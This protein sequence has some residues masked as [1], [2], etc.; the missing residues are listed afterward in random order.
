MIV[1]QLK[2]IS[3]NIKYSLAINFPSIAKPIQYRRYNKMLFPKVDVKLIP[4]AELFFINELIEPNTTVLDIGSNEGIFL[5]LF[6]KTNRYSR[7]IGF[8]PIPALNKRLKAF[9]PKLEVFDFAISNKTQTST[10][11]VPLI[12]NKRYDTRGTLEKFE[13]INET[14]SSTFEVK[15]ITLDEFVEKNNIQN[16]GGIKIDVEG[17]ELSAI[18]GAK[19]TLQQFHPFLMIEIE[20][21][22]HADVKIESIFKEVLDLGYVGRFFE[23]SIQKFLKIEEFNASVHQEN[24]KFYIN[25]FLFF[26]KNKEIDSKLTKL[27]NE[28]KLAL[29]S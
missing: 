1:N 26:D 24:T 15:T 23:P 8:E 16:I 2:N 10:F 27:E 7:I 6:E 11:K 18:L 4:E 22:H 9:F 13:E 28:Y 3:R 29:N 5:N 20:Q 12:N 25:N 19:K 14:G 21:R 17:H